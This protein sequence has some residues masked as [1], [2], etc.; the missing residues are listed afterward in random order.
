[1]PN[2]VLEEL[3]HQGDSEKKRHPGGPAV[4]ALCMFGNPANPQVAADQELSDVFD[5]IL[6]YRCWLSEMELG[7]LPLSI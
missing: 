4:D 2:V 6:F 5:I 1:M 7:P 3:W